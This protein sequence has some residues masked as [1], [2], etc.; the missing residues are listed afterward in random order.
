MPPHRIVLRVPA[1]QLHTHTG[2]AEATCPR[3]TLGKHIRR[4]SFSPPHGASPPKA[5]SRPPLASF[6]LSGIR[7]RP[8][9]TRRVAP[10]QR[11][12]RRAD[13]ASTTSHNRPLHSPPSSGVCLCPPP[14]A[15]AVAGKRGGGSPPEEGELNV[16]RRG[17]VAPR[18]SV[19]GRM[20]GGCWAFGAWMC[21]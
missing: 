15:Y 4:R 18:A 9:D 14:H 16:G 6:S 3:R 17:R 7:A 20:L 13:L 12:P 1:M 10:A 8:G 2:A 5:K 19:A 11:C 21:G